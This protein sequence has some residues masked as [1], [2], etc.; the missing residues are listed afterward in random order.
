METRT[1]SVFPKAQPH[2][3]EGRFREILADPSNSHIPRVDNAGTL[4]DGHVV[5]HNGLLVKANYYGDF[6]RILTLNKG[7]HESQEE[8]VF[9]EVLKHIQPGATMIE[10]GAYW[11][12]YSMWF[13]QQ[14]QNATNIMI[15]PN[16]EYLQ[17]GIDNFKLNGLKGRFFL[18]GIGPQGMNFNKFLS[19]HRIDYVDILHADIQGAELYLLGS[20]RDLLRMKKIG[21]FF[22]ST[23]S[24][25]LHTM[26][27]EFLEDHDYVILASADFDNETYC[28]DGVLVARDKSKSGLEPI[29]LDVRNKATI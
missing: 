10:L 25:D 11:A 4:Q 8:R 29:R 6:S 27:M 19:D 1:I 22:I 5:M 21:Y 15:E 28:F 14:I 7:V 2:D 16:R 26:C 20:I 12:F 23:H 24:Q 13:Q 9:M 17:C 3:F 18:G